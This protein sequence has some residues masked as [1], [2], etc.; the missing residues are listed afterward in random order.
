MATYKRNFKVSDYRFVIWEE[1]KSMNINDKNLQEARQLNQQ[2]R[3]K[4][5]NASKPMNSLANNGSNIQEARQLNQQS[6]EK[7]NS[8][9]FTNS[10]NNLE[11]TKKL[12]QQSRQNK[13]K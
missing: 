7:S 10:V 8:T 12:N 2:S 5:G 1:N 11:E 4:K 9:G 3:N 13:G 6:R